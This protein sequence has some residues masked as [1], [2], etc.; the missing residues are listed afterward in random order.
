M[1]ISIEQSCANDGE[2][3]ETIYS[4]KSANCHFNKFLPVS[5]LSSL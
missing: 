5:A 2:L 3:T 1:R 4:V